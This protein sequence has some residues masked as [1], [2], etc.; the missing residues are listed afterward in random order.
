MTRKT[1]ADRLQIALFRIVN[2]AEFTATLVFRIGK[3]RVIPMAIEFHCPHCSAAIRVPDAY[4][5]KKGSCPKCS[6]KLLVPDVVPPTAVATAPASPPAVPS[7]DDSVAAIGSVPPKVAD[8]A[9]IFGGVASQADAMPVFVPP[10]VNQPSISRKLKRKTRRKKS[11]TLY[12]WGIPAVCLMLFFSVVAFLM[13]QLEPELKG[14]LKGSVATVMEIPT[15]TMSWSDFELTPQ[16]MEVAKSSFEARESFISAQMACRISSG[17]GAGLDVDFEIGEEFSWYL[18]NPINDLILSDWIRDNAQQL[19]TRRIKEVTQAGTQLCRD[20]IR[21]ANGE[22]VVFAADVYRDNF[23]INSHVNAFGSVVEAIADNRASLCFH[24]DSN[25][26]LYFALPSGTTMFLLRG[27]S[28]GGP[29]LFP[30]EYTVFVDAA[31]TSSIVPESTTEPHTE[32]SD[33]MTDESEMP[34]EDVSDAELKMQ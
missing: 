26:T 22:P 28:F 30:G 32:S 15:A 25:G 17:S 2:R 13:Y 5:G 11:Q 1:C 16:E 7:S 12:T 33:E 18:V 21:K 24:E 8:A 20:K 29:A 31:S 34:M 9:E 10:P 27:R 6:Q 19:N 3:L 23:G 4:S 14:T